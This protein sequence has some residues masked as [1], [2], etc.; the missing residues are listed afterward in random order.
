MDAD[1]VFSVTIALVCAGAVLVRWRLLRERPVT[2]EGV[3]RCRIRVS[4]AEDGSKAW[5]RRPVNARWVHDVL[6]LDW[7]LLRRRRH[8][9]G[10]RTAFGVLDP[11]R[12]LTSDEGVVSIRLELDDGSIIEASA[13]ESDAEWLGGPFLCAHPVV[14]RTPP[15]R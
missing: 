13:R 10:V 1:I 9:L 14:R 8:A 5:P 11:T 12:T 15:L 4:G 3:F 6:V 2:P 7:G